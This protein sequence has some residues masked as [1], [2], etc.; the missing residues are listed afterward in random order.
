ML[1]DKWGNFLGGFLTVVAKGTRLEQLV[2]LALTRGIFLWD[3]KKTQEG[4]R[5]RVRNSA[6]PAL[7]NLAQE[8]GF[9]LEVAHRE[10]FPFY[11]Q[12]VRQRRMLLWGAGL[13]VLALYLLS[14]FVWVIEVKGNA[15]VP[16]GQIRQ[17]AA[18][19]GLYEG[20]L[21]WTLSK[22]DIEEGL[23]KDLLQLS[24]V[25]VNIKGVQAEI[26]VVEKILPDQ[27][28]GPCHI[29]ARKEGIIESVLVLKGQALVKE[30]ETVGQGDILI[31]GIVFPET[32]VTGDVRPGT[33][34]PQMVAAQ[35]QVKA[36]VWYEGYGECGMSEEK[37]VFTGRT[38]EK[39]EIVTPWVRFTLRDY[40]QK[41]AQSAEEEKAYLAPSPWGQWGWLAKISREKKTV[42][43][44]YSSQEALEKARNLAVERLKNQLGSGGK[45][46]DSG[47]K[48]LSSPAE[49]VV[50]VKAFA[51]VIEE[52]GVP[53]PINLDTNTH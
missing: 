15:K 4:I 44:T 14:S 9:A 41:F 30:Q 36:R 39:I 2:N 8:H 10:G 35:G 17:T 33:L 40:R 29:V 6:Y 3:V 49:P 13:F 31:S 7:Q 22:N 42:I 26:N 45:V 51:E 11:R 1:A 12:T 24:Y 52:I 37:T 25:E 19:H 27:P 50:R 47:I 20:A 28:A 53:Q 38:A 16:A 34:H 46:M 18:R 48:V 43:L 32:G 21:K 5:F 23:L